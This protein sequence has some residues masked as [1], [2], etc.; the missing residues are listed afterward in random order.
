MANLRNELQLLELIMAAAAHRPGLGFTYLSS[1]G[2]VYGDA[3]V[4]PTPEGC[5]AR[6]ISDY[7]WAKLAGEH[8]VRLTAHELD[9]R[10]RILRVANAYGPGQPTAGGQGVIGA[11]VRAAVTGANI[12]LLGE[13]RVVRDFVFIDDV[14]TAIL[15]T[16]DLPDEML[17]LNVGSGTGT[18]IGDVIAMV[19]QVTGLAVPVDHL[20]A[21]DCDVR[22]SLLDITRLQRRTGFVPTSLTAGLAASWAEVCDSPVRV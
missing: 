15:A 3:A 19:E 20:P 12:P 6:P 16:L 11:A 4:V 9:A 7:G 5:R 17:L 13:G 8:L 14:V 2:A 1:G 18:A 10:V 21:R 22:V